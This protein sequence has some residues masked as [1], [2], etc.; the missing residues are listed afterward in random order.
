MTARKDYR[1]YASSF[2]AGVRRSLG[3][4]AAAAH[5]RF[6]NEQ[7]YGHCAAGTQTAKIE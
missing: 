7:V 4:I 3:E 5:A 1:E 6:E 2:D